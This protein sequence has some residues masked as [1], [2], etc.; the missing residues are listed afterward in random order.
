MTRACL[1]ITAFL[2]TANVGYAQYARLPEIPATVYNV[3]DYGAVGDG[4]T[5]NTEAI[6][7]VLNLAKAS[8]GKV[9]IPAG[10]YLCGPLNMYGKTQLE[11]AKGATIR[12]Q[13]EI[14]PLREPAATGFEALF[15]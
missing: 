4:K 12:L 1:S 5:W 7:K 10:E 9:L 2:F 15:S 13:N 6:Q 14:D 8:G 11:I 3:K